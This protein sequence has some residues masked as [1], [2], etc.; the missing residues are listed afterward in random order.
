[1]SDDLTTNRDALLLR[2]RAEIK[3]NSETHSELEAFQNKSI[4]PVINPN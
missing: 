1:M 2:L 4:R 3:A